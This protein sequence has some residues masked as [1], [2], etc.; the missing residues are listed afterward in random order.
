MAAVPDDPLDSSRE[1]P[2]PEEPRISV[3]IPCRNGEATLGRQL[4]AL[5]GQTAS[6]PFEV[7]VADNGSTDGTTCLVASYTARDARIRLVDA[8][9]GAGI[10]VARNAGVLS[11]RGSFVLLCDADD[12]VQAG[13]LVAYAD[14]INAGAECV[15]GGV[16]RTLPDGTVVG[17]D[18]EFLRIGDWS[19]PSP[20]GAN[21]GFRRDVFDALGGFDEELAGGCDE[22]DFFWRAQSAGMSLTRVPGAVV[23]YYLRGR[24]G[25]VLRQNFS[26]AR[27]EVRLYLKHR[28]NGMPRARGR[29]L[30]LST[31]RA[32]LA[33]VL[34]GGTD[35][36]SRRRAVEMIGTSAGRLAESVR[37]RT[38]YF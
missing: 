22:I 6:V 34:R 7:V 2:A 20:V 3:V 9:Q 12:V 11:A 4:D 35:P 27:G 15:G 18:R 36:M 14:A 24:L 38:F 23:T 5:L 1:T 19:P 28:G 37:S 17:R 30:V 8:S 25:D 10:N 29:S 16:D 13:W 31:V 33:A 21:C 32:V 26:Y